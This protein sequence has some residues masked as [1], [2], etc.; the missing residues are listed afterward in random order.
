MVVLFLLTEW[1]VGS[2]T[3]ELQSLNVQNV[4]N[5]VS[6]STKLATLQDLTSHVFSPGRQLEVFP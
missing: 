4:L 2:V 5:V 1:D 6:V 3:K